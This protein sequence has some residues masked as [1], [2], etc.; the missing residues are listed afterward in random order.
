MIKK[1]IE[2]LC[3]PHTESTLSWIKK[4]NVPIIKVG[5]GELGNFEFLKNDRSLLWKISQHCRKRCLQSHED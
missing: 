1:K 2:F 4:L 5:S 3:T